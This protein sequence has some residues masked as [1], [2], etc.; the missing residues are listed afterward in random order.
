M[1]Q[2]T[3]TVGTLDARLDA[4]IRR[5]YSDVI[6]V[7]PDHFREWALEQVQEV[8]DFDAALWGT[9]ILITR[10]IHH[11]VQL[12]LDE[13]YPQ[14]V[15]NTLE[16]N[17]IQQAV[18]ANMGRPVTMSDV[19]DDDTF[20]QSEIYRK[21]FEPNGIQRIMSSGHLDMR[22]GLS[23]L[24]S[25]Y[26]RDRDRPFSEDDKYC[27]GRLVAHLMGA[28]SHAYFVHLEMRKLMHADY[29]A[30]LC[31]K[32]GFYWEA[33]ERFVNLLEAWFP[34]HRG[35]QLPFAITGV[36]AEF[37]VNGLLVKTLPVGGLTIV[38]LRPASP[39]DKLTQR[40][41]EIVHW[42]TRGL[43]FKEVARKL[44]VAPSTVSNH[45]YRIYR[46]LGVSSRTEL[47]QLEAREG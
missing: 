22:T 24:I 2:H 34:D 33:Q 21:L 15:A 29:C 37:V 45:L 16:I 39:M 20:Y 38:Y 23:S 19:V 31:D 4:L 11:V 26:R 10:T 14:L 17:P 7:P 8:V 43:S 3:P 36:Q 27:M 42:I 44:D 9:G 40:E 1:T 6:R 5:L 32:Q 13:H 12:G 18:L 28:A 41:R 47:A 30:A 46:K 25:V 35:M